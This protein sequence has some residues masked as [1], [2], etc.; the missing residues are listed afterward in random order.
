[1]KYKGNE[2]EEYAEAPLSERTAHRLE[3]C[4]KKELQK[5]AFELES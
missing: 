5:V 4:L 3:G 1:M 2:K